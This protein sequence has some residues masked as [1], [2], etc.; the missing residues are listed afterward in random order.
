MSEQGQGKNFFTFLVN[1]LRIVKAS[2]IKRFKK[3]I[4][5]KWSEKYLFKCV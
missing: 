1:E 2:N 4:I 3:F 5:F